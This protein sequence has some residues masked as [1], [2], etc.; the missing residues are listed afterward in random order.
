MIPV[1][2]NAIVVTPTVES[3]VIVYSLVDPGVWKISLIRI[4][5]LSVVSPDMFDPSDSNVK[6]DSCPLN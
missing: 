2:L 6:F 5:E 1:P 4:I 3:S